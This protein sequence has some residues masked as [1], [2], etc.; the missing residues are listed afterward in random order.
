MDTTLET[1]NK[2]AP[3]WSRPHI[4]T[5]KLLNSYTLCTIAGAPVSGTFHARRLKKFIPLRGS[6]LLHTQDNTI[7]DVLQDEEW[8]IREAELQMADTDYN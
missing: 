5:G 3:R 6:D 7:G 1:I 4:I 2:I 8:L